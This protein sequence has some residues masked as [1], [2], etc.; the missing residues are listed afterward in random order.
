VTSEQLTLVGIA[1]IVLLVAGLAG[2]AYSRRQRRARLQSRYGPEYDRTLQTAGKPT[3][4][5]AELKARAARVAE[6]KLHP[7]TSVQ[8]DA[9]EREW[10]RVQARFV[11]N[12]ED[13]VREA[14]I[15]VTQVMTARGYP[16][17]D[18]E[19]RAEDLSVNHP[20]VVQNYR[21]ARTLAA[22]RERGEAGTEELRQAVVN[23]RALLEDLL[24]TETG[25]HHR[26]AS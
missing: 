10:R 19:R 8:A 11:D 2:W 5:E 6:F 15:L 22:R 9:F 23:Y 1:L 26:L 18:F 3:A 4:A 24:E 25:R 7:I 20:A 21:T 12:P 13:A 17:E 14:D 16:L